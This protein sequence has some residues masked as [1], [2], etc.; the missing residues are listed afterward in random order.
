MQSAQNQQRCKW[1]S[2]AGYVARVLQGIVQRSAE[3]CW[4]GPQQLRDRRCLPLPPK[5]I[6]LLSCFR[7][8]RA[9]LVVFTSLLC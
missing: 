7:A 9:R 4:A 8:H 3:A 6:N 2:R 5:C 1:Q